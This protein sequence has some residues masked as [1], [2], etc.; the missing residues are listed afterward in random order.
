M[1]QPP[2]TALTAATGSHIRRPGRAAPRTSPV[3]RAANVSVGIE[4]AAQLPTRFTN[5]AQNDLLSAKPVPTK[6]VTVSAPNGG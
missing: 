5:G 4:S 3:P 2:V 1:T 6:M